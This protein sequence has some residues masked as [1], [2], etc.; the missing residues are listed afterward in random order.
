MRIRAGFVGAEQ[1]K[2]PTSC[3]IFFYLSVKLAFEQTIIQSH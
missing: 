3:Y 1:L 2:K